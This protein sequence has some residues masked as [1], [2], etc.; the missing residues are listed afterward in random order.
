MANLHISYFS[1]PIEGIW[2][3]ERTTLKEFV[4]TVF[5]ENHRLSPDRNGSTRLKEFSAGLFLLR[6][7]VS[8]LCLNANLTRLVAQR[9]GKRY[10]LFNKKSDD[11]RPLNH[12]FREAHMSDK[13]C[14]RNLRLTLTVIVCVFCVAVLA[15]M[16]TYE[17]AA[18]NALVI[19]GVG[20]LAILAITYFVYPQ[21]Y[22]KSR[23]A[24]QCYRQ[25]RQTEQQPGKSQ[26]CGQGAHRKNKPRY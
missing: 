5:S 16:A 13:K 9:V 1:H 23:G 10:R 14:Q 8:H 7:L 12:H 3:D 21:V 6:K 25:V 15:A 18:V 20:V 26:V 19:L 17:L 2:I 4:E 22:G 24:D 11:H